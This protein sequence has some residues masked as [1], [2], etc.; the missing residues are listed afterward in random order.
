MARDLSR[1]VKI[2]LSSIRGQ[3]AFAVTDSDKLNRILSD[4]DGYQVCMSVD[5]DAQAWVLCEKYCTVQ[6]GGQHF[7][8]TH[9]AAELERICGEMEDTYQQL[10]KGGLSS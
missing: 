7:I 8:V 9:N 4:K 1:N 6:E 2:L 5:N 10:K 3:F